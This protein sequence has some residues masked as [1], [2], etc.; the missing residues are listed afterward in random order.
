MKRNYSNAYHNLWNEYLTG[1]G[2]EIP[3][4]FSLWFELYRDQF[5]DKLESIEKNID[6]INLIIESV[7]NDLLQYDFLG[8]HLYGMAPEDLGPE[9]INEKA[10]SAAYG[11][12]LLDDIIDLYKNPFDPAAMFAC[13]QSL[14]EAAQYCG[15][16]LYRETLD[17]RRLSDAGRNGGKAKNKPAAELKAWA[18]EQANNLKM[19]DLEAAEYLA[20]SIPEHLADASKNPRQLI[21]RAL[22]ARHSAK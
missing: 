10:R 12:I 7:H 19:T 8:Y 15:I 1:S 11:I 13:H 5:L 16:I 3:D 6:A 14:I 17:K 18:T 2:V 21:Y 20:A 4:R 9:E 22:L